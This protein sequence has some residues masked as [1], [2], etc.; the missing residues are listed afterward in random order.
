MLMQMGSGKKME[1]QRFQLQEQHP[2]I[3]YLAYEGL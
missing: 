3:V 1:V 2:Y